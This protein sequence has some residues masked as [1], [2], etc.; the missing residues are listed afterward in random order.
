MTNDA[1]SNSIVKHTRTG[2]FH[3]YFQWQAGAAD[4]ALAPS[5]KGVDPFVK[6]KLGR[7]SPAMFLLEVVHPEHDVMASH[8]IDV[9]HVM[10]DTEPCRYTWGALE[11][12]QPVASMI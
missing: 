5:P 2:H 1:L 7:Y 3:T 12:A 10:D 8:L 4:I 11:T 9:Q 6:D